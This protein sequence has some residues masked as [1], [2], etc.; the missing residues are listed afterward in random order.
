MEDRSITPFSWG[1]IGLAILPGLL[2]V[3]A[4]SGL[5]GWILP[6]VQQ[7]IEQNNLIP[8][9]VALGIVVVGLVVERPLPVWGF[10]ALGIILL[11]SPGWVLALLALFWDPYVPFGQVPF[12]TLILVVLVTAAIFSVYQARKRYG[13]HIPRSG[14][15]LLGLLILVSLVG[16]VVEAGADRG[17]SA[18]ESFW[19]LLPVQLW[20]LGLILV[21]VAI[22][23]P[24]AR[25]N[26]IFAAL[27]VVAFE[28]VLVEEVLD[29][30]YSIDFW[31]YWEP[32]TAL[33][34]ARIVLAFLPALFFLVVAPIWVFRSPS[35]RGR[36]LG[37][38][39]PPLVALVG[40]DVLASIALRSTEAAYSFHSWFAH[41]VDTAQL[42][43]ALV[44]A[45]VVYH[46]AQVEK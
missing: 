23:L 44:L 29:P 36:V 34:L 41:G 15:L 40:I 3:G 39:L 2:I 9:Y 11:Q 13:I 10:P 38:L 6:G 45:A 18:W 14:W 5:F 25:R 24:L 17:L 30:T 12:S 4:R 20:W 28:F 26:G 37:L 31:A 16:G 32:T 46:S 21:P 43:L 19:V 22:G 8:V 35:L 33:E 7:A 27:V 42:L 1:K